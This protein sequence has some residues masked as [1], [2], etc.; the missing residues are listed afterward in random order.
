M[1]SVGIFYGPLICFTALWY[2]LWS[3]VKFWVRLVYFSRFGMLYKE[4]SG[5]TGFR[6]ERTS[7]Q[8]LNEAPAQ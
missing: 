8:W 4:K 2:T 6:C 7:L 1:E 5:N 3:F